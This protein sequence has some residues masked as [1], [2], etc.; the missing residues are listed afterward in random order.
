ML[1]ATNGAILVLTIVWHDWIEVINVAPDHHCGSLEWATVLVLL[2]GPR[3]GIGSRPA[4][5]ASDPG[6]TSLNA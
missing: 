6:L 2:L 5:V 4:G 3:D 1:P